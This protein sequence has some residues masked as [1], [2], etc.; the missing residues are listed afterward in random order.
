MNALLA[1][2]RSLG[3]MRLAAIAAVGLAT[4]AFFGFLIN[5]WSTPPMSLLYAQLDLRDSGQVVAK[6]EAMH[7]PY[8]LRADGAQILVPAD[9]VAR[10]RMTMAEHGLPN[11]GSIG[12]EIF[13]KGEGLE[14]SSFQQNMNQLRALEGELARTISSL[15]TVQA[16][17]VH[18]V[19]PKR[20]LFSRDRQEPSASIVVKLRG[21]E[22]LS[23]GQIA[24][25]QHL[26]AGAVP[27]LRPN[28]VV[29]VDAQ[30][31]LLAR[32]GGTDPAGTGQ[33]YED[34]RTA[35]ETR[36]GRA[37]ED[38]LDR[39]LGV[40]KARVEVH[41]DMDFD[42]V[43]TNTETYDPDGQVVRSTQT[44]K[45]TSNSGQNGGD[46]PVTVSTNLPDAQKPQQ[47][48]SGGGS[49]SK[50]GREEETTNYEISKTVKN[51][52]HE[53]GDVRRLSVAVLVDGTYTEADGKRTYQPRSPDELK[54]L[55]ALVKS[56]VGYDQKRGDAVEVVNLRFAVPDQPEAVPEKTY[57]GLGKD[58]LVRIGESAGLV[59]AALV[60][61]LL[62]V[63]PLMK[64]IF[65]T[66]PPAAPGEEIEQRLLTHAGATPALPPPGG[67]VVAADG[68]LDADQMIDIGQV[69][70]RVRASSVK[71]IGEIV[72]RHP[73]E[74]LS[75]V[76]SWMYQRS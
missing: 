71:K 34:V 15:A 69:E 23:R 50:S 57:L 61:I 38:M 8:Q 43:T 59:L 60:V 13:D 6:L 42:R 9:Q 31:T 11:G 27:E 35:Y 73:E 54:Q 29:I 18:L 72:E 10:L 44:S 21:S 36:L 17:R 70:G 55:A 28:R 74:A 49:Q 7:I 5:R 67:A 2:L 1:N 64:R 52:V 37:I 65:E 32:D 24:A 76:R 68:S 63:R 14:T 25:I 20:E 62:V 16:A 26:V 47:S 40:G 66:L 19:L 58:D 75:I 56:A 41:A 45:E 12:Y 53:G 46:Q 22:R 48:A 3:P 30:G 39:T 33:G 4:V 51:H